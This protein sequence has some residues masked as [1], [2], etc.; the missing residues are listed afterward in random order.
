MPE[1]A[2]HVIQ[3]QRVHL[4][5]QRNLRLLPQSRSGR[6]PRRPPT[7]A[8]FRRR[9]GDPVTTDQDV[10]RVKLRLAGQGVHVTT[11][12]SAG[13]LYVRVVSTTRT[14]PAAWMA[15]LCAFQPIDPAVSVDRREPTW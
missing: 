11:T 2:G 9:T 12:E 4:R 14:W 7:G 13:H 3:A 8:A 15:A 6:H 10:R 5:Q 1:G